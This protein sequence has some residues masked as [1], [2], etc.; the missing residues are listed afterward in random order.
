[1]IPCSAPSLAVGEDARARCCGVR[2]GAILRAHAPPPLPRPPRHPNSAAP[3]FAPRFGPP[4]RCGYPS[5]A[6]HV[7]CREYV[8]VSSPSIAV[9][10]P[11]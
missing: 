1:M 4:A 5:T 10:V 3:K 11:V 6:G 9:H 2:D 7:Q 8:V